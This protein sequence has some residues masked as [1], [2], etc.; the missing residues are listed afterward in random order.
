MLNI[1][2]VKYGTEVQ[3]FEIDQLTKDFLDPIVK[4]L[5]VDY[6]IHNIMHSN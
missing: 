6:K 4:N 1:C 3:G 5:K 2:L